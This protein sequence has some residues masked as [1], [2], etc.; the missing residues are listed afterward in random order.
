[1]TFVYKNWKLYKSKIIID[2]EKTENVFLFSRWRHRK[3]TPCD[4][5]KGYT[6]ELNKRTGLPYLR[7]ETNNIPFNRTK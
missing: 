1:M 4:L 6:V 2:D 3:C 5:P 7:Y